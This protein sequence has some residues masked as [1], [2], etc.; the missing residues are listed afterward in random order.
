MSFAGAGLAVRGAGTRSG[1]Q[2]RRLR[3][4]GSQG[5]DDSGVGRLA[6]RGACDA[7]LSFRGCTSRALLDIEVAH[8]ITA[9]GVLA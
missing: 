9:L 2:D 1:R 8:S 7:R 4:R 6:D 3:L 5:R